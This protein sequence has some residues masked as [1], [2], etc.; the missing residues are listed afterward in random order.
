MII[1]GTTLKG[2]NIGSF[3]LPDAPTIGVASATSSTSATIS[4]SAP[5]YT[6]GTPIVSY[7]VTSNT[8][9]SATSTSSPITIGGLTTGAYY[10]FSVTAT[11]IQGTSSPSSPSNSV[12]IDNIGQALWYST[13]GPYSATTPIVSYSTTTWTVPAGVTS[14]SVVCIGS[15]A[16]GGYRQTYVPPV[17]GSGGGL[18]YENNV[19]VT[20][21]ETLYIIYG[22][23]GGRP[24]VGDTGYYAPA[25]IVTRGNYYG[26]AGYS[27]ICGASGGRAGNYSGTGTSVIPVKGTPGNRIE[28]ASPLPEGYAGGNS[29]ILLVGTSGGYGRGGYGGVAQISGQVTYG[30]APLYV[31]GG[32]AP[33]AY[34]A[35]GANGATW[36]VNSSPYFNSAQAGTNGGGGGGG[37]AT[38]STQFG[39]RGGGTSPFGTYYGNGV[40]G[41]DGTSGG[42]GGDVNGYTFGAGGKC[43]PTS[44][45]WTTSSTAGQPGCVRIIWPGT[46]RRFPSTNVQDL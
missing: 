33:G 22:P 34:A 12:L 23:G 38:S 11:N 4:F 3:G 15:G 31:P 16:Y 42:D 28:G 32:G 29:S 17:A 24:S 6:G 30:S 1:Q 37:L 18:S 9:I 21:G 43:A 10:T 5:A 35:P 40:A 19:T 36:Y 25:S 13:A 44:A 8:G 14:I 20:P 39:G 41:V 46:S 27:M 26:S 2:G 7:T 45:A